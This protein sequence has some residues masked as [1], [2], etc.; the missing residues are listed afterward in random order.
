MKTCKICINWFFVSFLFFYSGILFSN[1]L[2][3]SNGA[4]V[5]S[6]PLATKV[7][8]KILAE[9]GNAYDAATAISAMLSV[10]EPFASGLGGG[11]FWLIYDAEN[12]EYKT[13]DARETAPF[14]SYKDMYLDENDNVIE[15][16]SRIGP[17]AAGI[18]GIPAVLSYVNTK[19]GSKKIATV[20][21]PAY[22]AANN[23]F[24]VNNK[25]IRGAKY[26]KEWLNKY[27]ETA[28]IF[29]N[30]GEVPKKGWILKQPDLAK[31]IKK[32]IKEGHK[33]FYAGNFAKKM[34]ESIQKEGGIWTEEDLNR[35]QVIEREPVR[36][37]YNEVSIIA[38][39]LPSSGGLVLSNALNILSGF[40][41]D[42]F[43]PTIR[44]HLI[45]EALR[46]AY[47]ERAIKMGD[48]DFMYESLAFLLSPSFS[49]KQRESINI[50][51][52]TDN[53]VLE[54]AE[55]PYQGQGNDTT[56]FA[57]IDKFGN[58][59]AVTQSINFWFGSAFV[60]EGTGILLNNEMDDFSIKPGT[61]NGYGLI[62]YNAN[63][64]EPG[65]RML[66]SMT[67][68]FLESDRGFVILGTPGGSRIISMI[69]LSALD[70]ING[71]D[72]KSM[73]SIPR[74]HHQ[75]YPDYVLY[76]DKAFSQIEINNLEEMGHK[77]KKSNRQ[78]GNMQVIQWDREKNE[79]Y[80][81]SDPRGR[82]KNLTDVY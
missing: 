71:G 64:I 63:A 75:Y 57:V 56:H 77:L 12:K 14:Q 20:L 54:F 13:L 22:H 7:G 46:R 11:A 4:V 18:P 5:T 39:G 67:P 61:E 19:Y 30:K 73:V 16:A 31:T 41:L 44:K 68:T 80:V 47:Y 42:K 32:I 15:N 35:Y 2:F 74:F 59:V 38:P 60:P 17:L 36:S 48:P 10:V 51:Y 72:A 69:L 65:K 62:G 23:G 50:N 76:E 79:I 49:A 24:P 55:P 28:K 45:I 66:S 53:K 70:W 52:A 26:K 82:E 40:D 34:V 25:Y 3:Q 37:T 78:F 43:K 58:R 21:G 8:E 9:G 33:G 1:E 27:K 81:A 29:L 6:N